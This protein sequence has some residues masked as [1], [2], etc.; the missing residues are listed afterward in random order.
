MKPSW[1]WDFYILSQILVASRTTD[2]FWSVL[3][4]HLPHVLC[5]YKRE[6]EVGHQEQES[7]ESWKA[8]GAGWGFWVLGDVHGIV[9]RGMEQGSF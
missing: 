1:K 8:P 2:E 5:G 9:H 4:S 7:E 6:E 3:V